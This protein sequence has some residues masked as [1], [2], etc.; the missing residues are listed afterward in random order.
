MCS[1]LFATSSTRA[2]GSVSFAVS[3]C[4]S[5]VRGYQ[6]KFER[7]EPMSD[8]YRNHPKVGRARQ[9][10]REAHYDLI[11]KRKH[12][13]AGR[14]CECSHRRDDHGP[15]YNINYT[16][17]VCLEGDCKCLNFLAMQTVK[18]RREGGGGK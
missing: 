7:R 9:L 18:A 10:L 5:I 17:G 3:A 13:E 14:V 6:V 1:S 12:K 8:E 16:G 2:V 11:E 4:S 15:S